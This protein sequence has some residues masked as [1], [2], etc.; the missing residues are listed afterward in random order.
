MSL[1][2]GLQLFNSQG[3]LV[4]ETLCPFT[5]YKQHVVELEPDERIVGFKARKQHE[6][7]A[8]YLDFQ[9]IIAKII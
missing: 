8:Y 9:L 7:A 2:R 1:L 3:E 6:E 4:L 5:Q